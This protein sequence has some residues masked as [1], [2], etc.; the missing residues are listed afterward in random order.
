M[1][2]VIH[3]VNKDTFLSMSCD[4]F[5]LLGPLTWDFILMVSHMGQLCLSRQ[6]VFHH[7][8]NT[9][10][11]ENKWQPWFQAAQLLQKLGAE[12]KGFAQSQLAGNAQR[13]WIP[14]LP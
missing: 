3:L 9:G 13:E 8:L 14:T 7:A 6:V 4:K 10:L 11:G 5:L 1:P 12:A 2:G